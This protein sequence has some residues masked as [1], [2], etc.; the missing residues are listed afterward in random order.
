VNTTAQQRHP[1]LDWDD[2]EI[3]SGGLS[4]EDQIK[5]EKAQLAAAEA[6]KA[7]RAIVPPNRFATEGHFISKVKRTQWK[8]FNFA[9]KDLG[10]AVGPS[11]LLIAA[12]YSGKSFLLQH[13]ALCAVSSRKL[14][15]RY[16]V[17]QGKVLHL[18]YEQG[19]DQ[20][21]VRYQRLMNGHGITEQDI[22]SGEL[23]FARPTMPLDHA[24]AEKELTLL[25]K[26][27]SICIIDSY[28]AALSRIDE[29]SSEARGPLTMLGNVSEATGCVFIVIHHQGKGD[30]PK[31]DRVWGRGSS[32][33][34][35][36]AGTVFSLKAGGGVYQLT[37]E[38]SRI[39]RFSGATYVLEDVGPTVDAI[40]QSE[41]VKLAPADGAT[42]QDTQRGQDQKA[43]IAV[44]RKHGELEAKELEEL[45]GI[46]HARYLVAR[47]TLAGDIVS[48]RKD[49]KD[50]RRTFCSIAP[51]YLARIEVREAVAAREGEPEPNAVRNYGYL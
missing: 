29:N 23:L 11:T 38:K 20:S 3:E 16:E 48:E 30:T 24:D 17:K 21:E 18:D 14:L 10:I 34:F 44:L 13:L 46:P 4:L 15:D 6:A 19:T 31:G 33:I 43:L 2:D 39:G 9:V 5:Y 47:K 7:P 27:Y 50:K 51:A 1:R 40:G 8:T 35:D 26:G 22:R 12:S 41:G 32:A 25:A 45:C 36:A 49:P 28:R 42:V 37:Q